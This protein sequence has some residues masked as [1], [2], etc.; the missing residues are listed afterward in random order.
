MSGGG[1]SSGGATQQSVQKTELPSWL[2]EYSQKTAAM[3]DAATSQPY[4]SYGGQRIAGFTGDQT[5]AQQAI[6]DNQGVTGAALGALGQRVQDMAGYTPQSV[7]AGTLPG[8]D[9]S[10]YINPHVANVEQHALKAIDDQRKLAANQIADRS[11]AGGAYGGSR[12]ALQQSANDA[13]AM[14]A[15]AR[16]SAGLRSDAFSN[17]QQMATQDINRGMQAGVFNS[18]QG[19]AG[20][21]VA[22]GALG[23]AGG[24]AGDAQRANYADIAALEGSGATQQGMTQA[25]LDVSYQDWLNSQNHALNMVGARAG[26]GAQIPYGQTVTMQS[27]SPTARGNPAMGALGGAMS[28]AAAGSMIM[29]GWGTAIGAVGG[30]L[31]GALG[32]R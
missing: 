27:N 16:T 25:G 8:T 22:L 26:I 18:Q 7:A 1:G 3:A 29:P 13:A 21:Q 14:Q 28:G 20:Q 23:M 30:G 11:I 12:F 24:F 31:L 4:Q 6:R 32:S 10:G 17:A 9:L 2:N 5:A 19:L 15:A